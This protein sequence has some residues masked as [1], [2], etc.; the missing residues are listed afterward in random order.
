MYLHIISIYL[1]SLVQN[2]SYMSIAYIVI[3]SASGSMNSWY[4]WLYPT[5]SF[6]DHMSKWHR[7]SYKMTCYF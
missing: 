1:L 6:Y 2:F 3:M 5:D 7:W 4:F